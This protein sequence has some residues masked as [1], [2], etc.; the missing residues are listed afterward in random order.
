M[1]CVFLQIDL[2]FLSNVAL[3]KQK[4]DESLNFRFRLVSTDNLVRSFWVKI[5]NQIFSKTDFV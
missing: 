1:K 4:T 3:N 2:V 5:A